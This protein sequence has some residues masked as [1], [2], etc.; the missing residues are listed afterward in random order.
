M[1]REPKSQFGVDQVEDAARKRPL[2]YDR[3]G[4]RHYDLASALIKSM[5]GGDPGASVYY[6]AAMLEGAARPPEALGIPLALP[7]WRK[8][9]WPWA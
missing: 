6:L 1:K 5:R 9:V 2:R 4:D 3:A 7:L 8:L